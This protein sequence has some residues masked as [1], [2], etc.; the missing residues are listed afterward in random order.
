M[1]PV[2]NRPGIM[3]DSCKV[4]QKCVDS[5]PP[6]R[7]ILSTLQT[8][9]YKLVKYL[10]VILASLTANKL[11]AKDSFNFRLHMHSTFTKML[12]EES[13]EICTSNL[14]KKNGIVQG[15]KKSQFEE[16]LSIVAE[17]PYFMFN[18]TSY[19]QF[20]LGAIRSPLG[21]SLANACLA[22]YE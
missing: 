19:K 17:E 14:F 1:K 20:D 18:N 16:L 22:H 7:P 13:I 8:P 10:V 9:M 4:Q 3:Y 6:F 15:L 21:P 12:L 11:T 2:G 5:C